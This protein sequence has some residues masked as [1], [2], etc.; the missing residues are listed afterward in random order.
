MK[1]MKN[2]HLLFFILGFMSLNVSNAQIDSLVFY[3]GN[4]L[5]GE[6]K[7]I[8]RGVLA[9]KT[10]YSGSDFNTEWEKS[11]KSLPKPIS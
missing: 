4:Y 8:S 9:A 6:V 5:V 7:A 10:D 3:N 2:L 11:K 1:N